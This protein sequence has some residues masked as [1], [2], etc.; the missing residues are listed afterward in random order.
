VKSQEL[1]SSCKCDPTS[2]FRFTPANT[3][4]TRKTLI[5]GV[6]SLVGSFCVNSAASEFAGPMA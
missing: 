2:D 6:S 4:S 5:I 3:Y 1:A